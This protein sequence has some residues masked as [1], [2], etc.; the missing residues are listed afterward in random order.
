MS[1]DVLGCK[2]NLGAS[3]DISAAELFLENDSEETA[4]LRH[5]VLPK[6]MMLSKEYRV[7]RNALSDCDVC[8][9]EATEKSL[10]AV[11]TRNSLSCLSAIVVTA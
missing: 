8:H 1:K 4:S 9:T 5:S 11:T 10:S 2:T 6:N 3:E 7:K